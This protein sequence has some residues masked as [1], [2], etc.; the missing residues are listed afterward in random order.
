MP[1]SW[2]LPVQL[3]TKAGLVRYVGSAASEVVRAWPSVIVSSGPVAEA[4]RVQAWGV[5]PGL[6]VDDAAARQLEDVLADAVPAVVDAD[7]LTLLAQ[8]S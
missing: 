4:G 1:R 3:H 7:G 2:R 6:G 5:G 8:F